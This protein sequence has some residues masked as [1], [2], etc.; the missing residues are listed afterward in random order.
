MRFS[1]QKVDK[2]WTPYDSV[3]YNITLDLIRG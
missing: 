2:A 1:G 3:C